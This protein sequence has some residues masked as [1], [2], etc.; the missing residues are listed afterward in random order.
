[1]GG[2][3]KTHRSGIGV[4]L[5][6]AVLVACAGVALLAF[7]EDPTRIDPGAFRFD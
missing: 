1:M 2:F 4:A 7:L 3:R 6:F 5:T